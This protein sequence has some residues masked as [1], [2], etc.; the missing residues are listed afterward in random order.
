MPRDD[1][2]RLPFSSSGLALT[3]TSAA[4][5]ICRKFIALSI[6]D[7]G[8][9]VVFSCQ[10]AP[11]ECGTA[12]AITG[13]AEIYFVYLMEETLLKIKFYALCMSLVFAL[14]PLT[15]AVAQTTNGQGNWSAVQTLSSG[16]KLNIEMKSGERIEGKFS[17]ATDATLA[18]KQDG[19]STTL[20]RAD[21]RRVS[22]THGS[23]RTKW[24]LIGAGVGG[25]AGAGAGGYAIARGS[26]NVGF[27]PGG[28][29]LGAAIGAG[30][31]AA[32]G[33]SKRSVVIYESN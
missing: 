29:A 31:G 23:S 5:A 12:L 25:G 8:R 11:E 33:K 1:V 21:I 18:V 24:A 17:S 30:I 26:E 7:R 4:L 2:R 14:A 15:H 27:I 22:R 20:D 32:I 6:N 3:H 19:K 16:D 10:C 28:A 13:V 9:E